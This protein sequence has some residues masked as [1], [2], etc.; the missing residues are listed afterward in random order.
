MADA[1]A[2]FRRSTRMQDRSI[3]DQR[4]V[5]GYYAE[6]HDYTILREF[7]DDGISGA[8]EA[9]KRKG[10]LDMIE[11]V[12]NGNNSVQALLVYDISR[13]ARTSSDEAGYYR[14]RLQMAG[15]KVVYVVEN[16]PQDDSKDLVVD[17]LQ[18]Q[19]QEYL[20]QSARD[21]LR[22]IKSG[23]MRGGRSGG[24]APFGYRRCLVN[25]DGTSEI[26]RR[27]Q[28][29]PRMQGSKIVLVPACHEEVST[30]KKIFRLYVKKGLGCRKIAE[31][32]N[33]KGLPSP[34]SSRASSTKGW[35]GRTLAYIL[36]NPV[37][38]GDTCYNRLSRAKVCALRNGAVVTL[39]EEEGLKKNLE[40]EWIIARNTHEPL[41]SRRL[42][43]QAQAI[44]QERCKQISRLKRQQEN[45]YGNGG[46]KHIYLLSGLV[47]CA[48]CS[49]KL[50]GFA[51]GVRTN[52]LKK[53]RFYRCTTGMFKGRPFC[54]P[55]TVRADKVDRFILQVVLERLTRQPVGVR[56]GEEFRSCL[57]AVADM[58]R[59]HDLLRFDRR[60]L[61]STDNCRMYAEIHGSR[62]RSLSRQC[63]RARIPHWFGI[64]IQ[65][66]E[67]P[68]ELDSDYELQAIRAAGQDSINSALQVARCFIRKVTLR[69]RNTS[70]RGA[71]R[72]YRL[73][74]G[75]IEIRRNPC[76]AN[77]APGS[78]REETQTDDIELV[79]FDQS[80]IDKF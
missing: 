52:R 51:H 49:G 40:H 78:H 63:K 30:V 77:C 74:E 18:W 72:A 14:Y 27:G 64:T 15:C 8:A 46:S 47:F 71:R 48:K 16:L 35:D 62:V 6:Q 66:V 53:H 67:R 69:I 44:R 75:V 57:S 21:T 38:V 54:L 28:R 20:R 60:E 2:Y 10:F 80:D 33:R 19:K 32:L 29:I 5:V 37:Y 12:E 58:V 50:F 36:Q 43:K 70:K 13:F 55:Y 3:S 26:L 17:V 23:I 11:F 73:Q 42:F 79:R 76:S 9:A 34:T 45:G 68:V 59:M 41:V 4:Q 61:T 31:A 25:P 7:I 65:G 22:G 56:V 1:V 39:E 24:I